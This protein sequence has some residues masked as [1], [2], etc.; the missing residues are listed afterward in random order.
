MPDFFRSCR[1]SVVP[2]A[3]FPVAL[4]SLA[5][6]SPI[7]LRGV[8]EPRV[9]GR[10]NS[11]MKIMWDK[12]NVF[13]SNSRMVPKLEWHL[14]FPPLEMR[15]DLEVG[16]GSVS[17]ERLLP[18][19]RQLRERAIFLGFQRL[20][21][22]VSHLE[23]ER[24]SL[25]LSPATEALIDGFFENNIDTRIGCRHIASPKPL[26]HEKSVTHVMDLGKI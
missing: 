8:R 25:S 14:P 9:D 24:D 2:D 19:F 13:V 5:K 15:P 11:S 4:Q 20:L 12:G 16:L 22:E 26:L 1:P 17:V 23:R 7:L 6:G 10:G 18:R 3:Q 21:D